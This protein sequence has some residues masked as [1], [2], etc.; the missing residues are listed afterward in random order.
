MY[1]LMI[2]L[3]RKYSYRVAYVRL[4]NIL[5]KYIA[6]RFL[7]DPTTELASAIHQRSR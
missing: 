5:A 2:L 1:N 7:I 4:I 6:R 3:I